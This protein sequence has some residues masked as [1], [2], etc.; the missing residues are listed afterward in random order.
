MA[1]GIHST[2][3]K[4][5]FALTPLVLCLSVYS[6]YRWRIRS[7]D[8]PHEADIFNVVE[9]RWTFSGAT[10]NC[11]SQA[12]TVSFTPNHRDMIL[13]WPAAMLGPAATHDSIGHYPVL[14]HTRHSIRIVRPGE[15]VLASDSTPVVWDLTLR[16]SRTYAWHRSDWLPVSFTRQYERCPK[17]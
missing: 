17:K 11:D 8:V 1:S 6:F 10:G 2:V 14:G 3:P 9:G 4:L 12:V 16:S 15:T 13:A 7:Y 5:A